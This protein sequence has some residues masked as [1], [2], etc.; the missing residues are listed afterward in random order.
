MS[1][2]GHLLQP[3]ALAVGLSPAA[4]V[5]QGI[6]ISYHNLQ[7]LLL[8]AV[9]LAGHGSVGLRGKEYH[10]T[11]VNFPILQEVPTVPIVGTAGQLT[12]EAKT[13]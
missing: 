1:A 13:G 11:N 2:Q 8:S 10:V 4:G 6:T 9:L 5:P 7:T 3:L 12:R